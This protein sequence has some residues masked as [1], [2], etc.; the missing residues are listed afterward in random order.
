MG[1]KYAILG[2]GGSFAIHT[3]FYLLDQE[4]TELVVGIGRNPLREEM[5][6]LNID[7]KKKY[8][9]LTYHIY[10]EMDLM[11]EQLD[12]LKPDIIICY[13]AQGEGAVSWKNSWRFFETN[14]V[15]L[16]KLVEELSKRNYLK[17]FIQIGTSELYGSVASPSKEESQV[18]PS[19]PYAASKLAFD[20]YLL[21]AFKFLKFPMNIIRPSNAYCSGQLLHRIVPRSVVS[22][23]LKQ[24]VPLHGGGKAEKS[25]IHARDLAEAIYLVVK[26]G[27]MGEVYNVGPDKPISIKDLCLKIS[28]CLNVSFDSLYDISDDRLGQDSRYWLNSDKIKSLGWS[29]K[30]ELQEGIFEV[31]KWAEKYL[32]S[33]ARASKNYVMRG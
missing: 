14:S 18:L 2:G 8:K 22:G 33:L 16:T 30:I 21:S 28:D 10:Y 17:N 31:R 1:I 26:K 9:Y 23:L 29:Q 3:S 32:D 4:D 19:S 25:Y 11:L 24:K 27:K 15:A 7:K 5:F 12:Q 13:A 20:Y 6:S